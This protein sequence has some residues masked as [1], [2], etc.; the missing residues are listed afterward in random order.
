[1]ELIRKAMVKFQKLQPK[2]KMALLKKYKKQ[3]IS[4]FGVEDLKVVIK[5]LK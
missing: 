2:D 5:T 1:M 4:Q 3:S